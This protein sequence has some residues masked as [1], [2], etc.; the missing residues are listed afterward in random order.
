MPRD[1][2]ITV[3][4]FYDATLTSALRDRLLPAKAAAIYIDCDLYRST[5]PVLE[6]IVPFLQKGTVIVFDDWNCY[7]ADP[8][9]GERRA[10]AEFILA[11][12]TLR[13]EPFISTSEAASFIFIGDRP[14]DGSD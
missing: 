4:G 9:R 11:H 3:K 10:W 13:F 1:R 5:I 6:F 8:E 14:P 12:P 7:H 2:L